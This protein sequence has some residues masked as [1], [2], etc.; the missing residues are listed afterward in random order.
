MSDS[1][2]NLIPKG[3]INIPANT[4]ING[5]KVV[6]QTQ[7]IA[8]KYENKN[9]YIDI[10]PYDDSRVILDPKNNE[11]SDYINASH[12]EDFSGGYKVILSQ[13]PMEETF[14]DFYLMLKQQKVKRI[15]MVTN[16]VEQ[17]K[18]KCFAY[19]SPSDNKIMEKK[20]LDDYLDIVGIKY[21]TF[22][23]NIPTISQNGIENITD[24][25]IDEYLE[26]E[27]LVIN[28]FRKREKV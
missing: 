14:K 13:G 25:L 24:L 2:P 7:I 23:F 22:R 17:G 18:L 8:K 16:L 19:I 15:V 10:L 1:I 9:R 21:N 11:N 3:F 27:E 26:T 20:Q 6:N 5:I 4:K 12:M 28:C